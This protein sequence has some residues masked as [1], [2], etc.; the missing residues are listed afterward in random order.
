MRGEINSKERRRE[1]KKT[2]EMV[3]GM[4]ART[5]T[6]GVGSLLPDVVLLLDSIYG[7][8]PLYLLVL[9]VLL[10]REEGQLVDA[11]LAV[12]LD[13]VPD[14]CFRGRPTFVFRLR[15]ICVLGRLPCELRNKGEAKMEK[16]NKTKKKKKKEKRCRIRTHG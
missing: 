15:A 5:K 4:W 2:R 9:Q 6:V 3:A 16:M 14:V 11:L 7:L 13:L 1:E 8:L 10:V 12:A